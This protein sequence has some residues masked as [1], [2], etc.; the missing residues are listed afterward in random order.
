MTQELIER[1]RQRHALAGLPVILIVLSLVVSLMIAAIAVSV[2]IAR[3]DSLMPSAN[4][5]SSWLV[6][7]LFVGFVLVSMG[8]LTAVIV[9]SDGRPRRLS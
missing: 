1:S 3:A 2:G 6:F 9:K 4:G 5:G 7:A 8:G